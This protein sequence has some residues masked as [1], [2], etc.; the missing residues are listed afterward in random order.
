LIDAFCSVIFF[1][2]FKEEEEEDTSIYVG[3]GSINS[4]QA[5]TTIAR[6]D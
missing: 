1:L 5:A 4:T 6:R 3:V 2:H